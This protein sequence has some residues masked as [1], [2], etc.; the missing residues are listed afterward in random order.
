M[1]TLY[2]VASQALHML[3]EPRLADYELTGLVLRGGFSV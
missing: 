2:T 1:L 3:L